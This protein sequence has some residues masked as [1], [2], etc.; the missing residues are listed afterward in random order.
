VPAHRR[1]LDG[2]VARGRVT[3]AL[4][5]ESLVALV[6]GD[7][8]GGVPTTR[9]VAERA[10]VSVRVVFHHFPSAPDLAAA[11]VVLQSERHRGVLFAVPPRGP[12]ELRVRAL[13]RQRRLYFE[14]L[15]PI[16]RVAAARAPTSAAL[17]RFHVEDRQR[18]RRQLA[19]ALAPEVRDRGDEADA[20]LD[21]LE[22]V[23]GWDAWRALR[24]G[25]GRSPAAAE[26]AMAFT[27]V[28]LLA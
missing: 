14:A 3:R 21:A 8:D 13:C 2:R 1:H 9:Q 20:L 7:G 15:G 24:D 6:D 11:A 22:H 26:R 17:A 4:L 25:W 27:A 18:L 16:H 5:V 19:V 28:R 23:T 10:G 12:P